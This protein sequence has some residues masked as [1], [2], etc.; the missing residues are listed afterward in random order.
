MLIAA[1][2]SWAKRDLPDKKV[3]GLDC[4]WIEKYKKENQLP[5][6][7]VC[8]P[9]IEEYEGREYKPAYFYPYRFWFRQRIVYKEHILCIS[10]KKV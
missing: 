9:L 6:D 3:A 2:A 5:A 1:V 8:W 4:E 10:K 7:S